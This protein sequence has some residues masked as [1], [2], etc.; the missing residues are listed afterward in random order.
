[1]LTAYS[2]FS[3]HSNAVVGTIRWPE[4]RPSE[5]DIPT[6]AMTPSAA[7]PA[8]VIELESRFR[9]ALRN[10]NNNG[11]ASDETRRKVVFRSKELTIRW[12]ARST[13][14]AAGAKYRSTMYR[15]GDNNS[16]AATVARGLARSGG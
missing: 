2:M 12:W 11:I 7:P 3:R 15:H 8:N 14:R 13:R 6:T 10:P 9:H 1:M 16:P 4:F 5:I